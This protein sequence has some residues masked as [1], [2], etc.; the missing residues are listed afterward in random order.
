LPKGKKENENDIREL[1]MLLID[2]AKTK[3][4]YP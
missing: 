1:K 4:D 3:I 2:A